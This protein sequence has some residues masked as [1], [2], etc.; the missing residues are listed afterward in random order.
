MASRKNL[1]SAIVLA[2]NEEK[3]IKEC[4]RTLKWCDE[5]I[6]MDDYSDDE[7]IKKCQMSNVKCQIYKRHLNEDFAGQRNFGLEKAVGEWVLFVDADERISAALTAEIQCQMSNVKCQIYEGYYFR[8]QDFLFGKW[9]S[10]GETGNIKLL[11]LAKKEAGRWVRPVHEIW[12]VRGKIGELKNSLLHYPH[13]TIKEFLE[14]I[15]FY[16]TLNARVFFNQ[17]IKSSWWQIVAYPVA[18]FG[19]NYFFQCGFLDGMAGLLQAIFMS[20]HSF[21][22]RAKLW[23]LWQKNENI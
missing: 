19:K 23:L 1:I 2:K 15:N 10:H 6:I 16:T 8:R 13:Q 17:G 18:K 3:N 21:L 14:N 9:L 11:R 20:F 22:T 5:I 4:L 7:T 12:E